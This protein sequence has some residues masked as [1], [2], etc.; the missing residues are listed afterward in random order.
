MGGVFIREA[1]CSSSFNRAVAS[2]CLHRSSS[3]S[4]NAIGAC[5]CVRM[6]LRVLRAGVDVACVFALFCTITSVVG[7]ITR[8]LWRELDCSISSVLSCVLSSVLSSV[9]VSVRVGAGAGKGWGF[10]FG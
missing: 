1:A 7:V 9:F 4:D 10:L 2:T 6:L 3:S 5:A 8:L